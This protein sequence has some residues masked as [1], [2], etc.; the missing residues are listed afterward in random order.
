MLIKGP[1]RTEGGRV[2]GEP[3]LEVGSLRSLLSD[4]VTLTRNMLLFWASAKVAMRGS[5]GD[6][7]EIGRCVQLGVAM[8]T[9][10]HPSDGQGKPS[11][12]MQS[13]MK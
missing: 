10:G 13:V 2:A 11:D 6:V 7:P 3:G 9:F 5:G 8:I 12:M 4:P 1:V